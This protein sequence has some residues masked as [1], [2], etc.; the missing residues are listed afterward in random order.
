MTHGQLISYKRLSLNFTSNSSQ[1]TTLPYWF[2]V[3]NMWSG[4]VEN[5]LYWVWI[6]KCHKSKAPFYEKTQ[7]TWNTKHHQKYFVNPQFST[8]G[9]YFTISKQHGVF[10][11]ERGGEHLFKGNITHIFPKCDFFL[12][13]KS[14]CQQHY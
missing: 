5:L 9:I 7:Y 13:I 10:F 1:L 11:R 12:N 4:M 14:A 3:H 2:L 8:L 6:L